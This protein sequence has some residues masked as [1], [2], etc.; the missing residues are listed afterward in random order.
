[1]F[2]V[3]RRGRGWRAESRGQPTSVDRPGSHGHS[4]GSHQPWQVL[5]PA[6]CAALEGVGD[7][8]IQN[9]PQARQELRVWRVGMSGERLS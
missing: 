2:Y 7:G 1:V 6:P 5:L 8:V 3:K 4:Q 9:L